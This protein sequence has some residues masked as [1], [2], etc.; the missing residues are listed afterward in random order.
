MSLRRWWCTALTQIKRGWASR[1]KAAELEAQA[2]AVSAACLID[3]KLCIGRLRTRILHCCA[4]H[5]EGS[6]ESNRLSRPRP[7]IA[8]RFSALKC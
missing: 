6:D 2:C 4:N 3:V 8:R 5:R 7:E 1:V